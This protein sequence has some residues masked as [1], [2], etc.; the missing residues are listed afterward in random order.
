[1]IYSNDLM[2]MAITLMFGSMK[3]SIKDFCQMARTSRH[4]GF[5]RVRY[6]T[7]MRMR[8]N[9]TLFLEAINSENFIFSAPNNTF[10][11]QAI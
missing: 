10:W 11:L 4:L 5:L 9:N 6:W 1:M 7:T 2:Q 8:R 3:A